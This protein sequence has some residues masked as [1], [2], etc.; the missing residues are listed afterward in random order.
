MGLG[1][2]SPFREEC[3]FG[4]G[5]RDLH[6]ILP[7]ALPSDG[8]QPHPPQLTSMDQLLYMELISMVFN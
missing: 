2:D 4:N 1:T 6:R 7:Y 5:I 3:G 8:L